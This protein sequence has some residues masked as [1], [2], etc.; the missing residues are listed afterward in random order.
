MLEI[1]Q[2]SAAFASTPSSLRGSLTHY[3]VFPH[4]I[5]MVLLR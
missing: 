3:A 2:H 4:N 5:E 1:S